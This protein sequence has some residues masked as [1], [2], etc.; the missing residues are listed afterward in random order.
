MRD[1]IGFP[2]IGLHQ[3]RHSNLTRMGRHMS[4]WDLMRYAGWSSPEPAKIYIHDDYEFMVKRVCEA[5]DIA[6]A[7]LFRMVA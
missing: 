3:L 1:G 7:E 5:W 4:T 2:G 6:P